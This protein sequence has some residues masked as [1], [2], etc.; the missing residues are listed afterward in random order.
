MHADHAAYAAVRGLPRLSVDAGNPIPDLELAG[1]ALYGPTAASLHARFPGPNLEDALRAALASGADAVAATRGGDGWVAATGEAEVLAVP[2]VEV[3][4]V[5]TLGAGDVFHGALLAQP[6]LG[7][8]LAEAPDA[9]N[10]CAALSCRALDGRSGI[11]TA[12]E[13]VAS[14]A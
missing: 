6:A 2:G 5:G 3:D 4:A 12:G 14:A 10:R 1:V 11:A 13:L 7:V 9:A 8:H